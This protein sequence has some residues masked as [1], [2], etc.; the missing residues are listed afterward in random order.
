MSTAHPQRVTIV[1]AGLAGSLLAC[2]LAKAGS[3]VDV[4]E[5]RSDPRAKG[6]VGGRSINLALS[7]RGLWG[8]AGVGLDSL[9][10]QR[11]ALPMRGRIIHPV[12]APAGGEGLIFQPYS[13]DPS[14]AINSVSRGGLN[15]TL[16]NA[17]AALPGVRFH[18]DHPCVDVDLA[19]KGGGPAAI[20]ETG[21][22]KQARVESDLVIGTDGAFSAVRLR[23]LKTDRFDYSQ[24]YLAHGYKELMI[25]PAAE[26]S[27]VAL[28]AMGR[29]PDGVDYDGYALNP[30]ALHIWPRGGAMM[31]ALPNRDKSFTCTLFWPHD[32]PHGLS[33]LTSEAQ[34]RAFFEQHYP[35]AAS[36]MPTLEHDYLTNPNGSLVTVRCWPWQFDGKVAL[37]GDA[38]HAIVPFYGQGMNCAFEDCRVLARCLSEHADAGD[39]L[40][41]YQS[42]R[43]PN[44]DAI[45]EMALDNFIEMR[46][47]V[48]SPDF[49]YQK[50]V[51][52]TLHRFFPAKVHPQYNMVSFSTVPYVEARRSGAELAAVVA[53]VVER[54]PRDE[55][56][57]L[58]EE[59]WEATV[60]NVGAEVL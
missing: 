31:I 43:K 2:Y 36:I 1:G 54:V 18:F 11:D 48:G 37:V 15:L 46:D 17:A 52:Q 44:A 50:K 19:E 30:E 4:Y 39:A 5:R 58:G 7:V 55:L 3:I 51:E 42:E 60:R 47:K 13:K 32:G 21:P 49:L 20:F 28:S 38:A 8:L 10:M 45:A 23:L 24:A 40:L 41:A 16:L 12:V 22:G 27:P 56:A 34:V 6:Y 57:K 53:K 14:D 59:R 25:P 26:L 33:S 9:V 35:D 29:K